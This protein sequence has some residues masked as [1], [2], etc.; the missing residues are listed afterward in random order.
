MLP[1]LEFGPK[2]DF[3]AN[4]SKLIPLAIFLISIL[5]QM[6]SIFGYCHN[7]YFEELKFYQ[8]LCFVTNL[9]L[10]HFEFCHNLIFF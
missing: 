6:L 9:V 10:P 3:V 5:N 7:L 4:L 1:H 8:N 2:I